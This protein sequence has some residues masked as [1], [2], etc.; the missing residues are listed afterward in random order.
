MQ[1][2]RDIPAGCV[3]MQ[4]RAEQS[5]PPGQATRPQLWEKRRDEPCMSLA[6]KLCQVSPS[7]CFPCSALSLTPG[8]VQ[9]AEGAC[10][11]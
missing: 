1:G 7:S 11:L 9:H 4:G 5:R 3:G 2:H 10:L 8:R 6:A